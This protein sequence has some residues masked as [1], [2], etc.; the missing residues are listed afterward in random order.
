MTSLI[1]L[2]GIKS[3]I[4]S[5]TIE[6][7]NSFEKLKKYKEFIQILKEKRENVQYNLCE[8]EKLNHTKIKEFI[9]ACKLELY[10]LNQ[11]KRETLLK[12]VF[13]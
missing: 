10:E 2:Y 5:C 7:V 6:L 4:H 11:E 9:N 8:V 12:Q 13:G 3:N 1:T